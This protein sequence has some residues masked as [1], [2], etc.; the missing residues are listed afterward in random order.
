MVKRVLTYKLGP[1]FFL[2]A[3]LVGI[4]AGGPMAQAQVPVNVTIS[5]EVGD[6]DEGIQ[7]ATVGVYDV[8]NDPKDTDITNGQG[9]FELNFVVN[10]PDAEDAVWLYPGVRQDDGVYVRT[11]G[12]FAAI[13]KSDDPVNITDVELALFEKELIDSILNEVDEVAEDVDPNLGLVAGVV[14]IE[15]DDPQG[16]DDLRAL[17][18]ATVTWT[19]LNGDPVNAELIYF[20]ED[21]EEAG[22]PGALDSSLTATSGSGAFLLYNIVLDGDN[23]RDLKLTATKSG[24]TIPSVR[25]RAFPYTGEEY[26][27][28]T[29]AD[30]MGSEGEAAPAGD[31]GGG[32]GG[33]F[34]STA[35]H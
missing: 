29:F 26:N 17:D 11:Y 27:A 33:C 23:E 13:S 14:E 24:Y 18:G 28:I 20:G 21:P 7:G 30:F 35:G 9:Q 10:I 5:G 15:I 31:G 19:D 2:C 8:A 6:E 3:L 34:I 22:E 16:G 4:M 25:V 12:P 32:G 1:V